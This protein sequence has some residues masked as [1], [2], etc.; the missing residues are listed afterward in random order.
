MI[1]LAYIYGKDAGVHPLFVHSLTLVL[2]YGRELLS[3]KLP[4]ISNGGNNIVEQRNQVVRSFLEDSDADWLLFVDTDQTF[5]QHLPRR[6][7][8][9]ADPESRPV[10]SALVMAQRNPPHRPITPAFV[11]EFN[12]RFVVPDT[13]PSGV[14][15]C[16]PGAG[17]V[18]IHRTVLQAIR[19]KFEPHTAFPWFAHTE[20]RTDAGWDSLGEDY[21][22]MTRARALGFPTCVD[23]TIHVG[24]VK[25]VVLTTQHFWSQ[26]V[27]S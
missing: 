3:K 18:L 5:D 11:V 26:F 14:V 27:A 12:G 20:H 24:H 19:E 8:A 4:V 25:E 6:L 9:S 17:C 10:V 15:D 1:T 23:T 2:L 13:I 22:F 21:T 7:L 16:I